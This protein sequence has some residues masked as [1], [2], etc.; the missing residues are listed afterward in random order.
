[1]IPVPPSFVDRGFYALL[2]PHVLLPG[3]CWPGL[4]WPV[5]WDTNFQA[6]VMTSVMERRMELLITE[7]SWYALHVIV[8]P[9]AACGLQQLCCTCCYQLLL[10]ILL[11]MLKTNG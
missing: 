5:S 10:L 7:S 8:T 2:E 6:S 9:A 11:L 4:A 1:M 3:P